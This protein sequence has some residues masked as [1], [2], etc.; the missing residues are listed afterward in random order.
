MVPDLSAP[1]DGERLTLLTEAPGA[2]LVR[3][4]FWA[5]ILGVVLVLAVPSLRSRRWLVWTVVGGFAVLMI[6]GLLWTYMI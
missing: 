5:L 4:L 1:S 2:A 6:G 3:G